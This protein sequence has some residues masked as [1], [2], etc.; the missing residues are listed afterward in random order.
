MKAINRRQLSSVYYIYKGRKVEQYIIK[1][2]QEHELEL[3]AFSA[4]IFKD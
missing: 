1:D 4:F 2:F 3:K